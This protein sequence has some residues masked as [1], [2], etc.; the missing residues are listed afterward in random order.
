MM[1]LIDPAVRSS[2]ILLVGL[3]VREMLRRR[4]AAGHLL[5]LAT[6][7]RPAA[8][9]W[10]SATLMARP[11]T[12]ERRIAAML[13][14]HLDH[15]H[16]S[17][18]AIVVTALL[19]VGVTLP[20]AAF[21]AAQTSPLPLRG[22][23]YDPTGA[24]LPGVEL[25]L[26]DSQ[27]GQ[28]KATSDAT[29]H[30]E[31]PSVAPGRYE[32]QAAL[33]GFRPLRHEFDLRSARD[34]DRAITLQVGELQET[35]TVREQR[36]P[37]QPAVQPQTAQ[38][39]RIGGNIRPPLKLYDVRPVYPPAM[40]AAGREGMVPIE[41]LIGRDGVVHSLRVLSAQVHPDF[42]M[43]AMEAVRQWRFSPTLLNGEPVEVVMTVSVTFS[44]S[45]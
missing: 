17:P 43:A 36:L 9:P 10:A 45:E 3:V 32:L 28:L 5:E 21:R 14:P 38:P 26:V 41:A 6:I 4:S 8:R 22:T 30:F 18:R 20:A 15:R 11:S 42:A 35:I 33:A 1:L 19:L 37:T 25:T 7:C 31:F 39:I 12:L 13:N 24:V 23:V 27:Q 16:L 2:L 44:L 29:G 40:R 34:W